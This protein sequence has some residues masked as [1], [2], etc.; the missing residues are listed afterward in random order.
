MAC[1]G[2][3]AIQLCRMEGGM[4]VPGWDTAQ[5]FENPEFERSPI[6]LGMS[7][8]VGFDREDDFRG[9]AALIKEK[10]E[11][12]RYKMKGFTIA[13][14]CELEDG[15][16]LF[17]SIDGSDVKIGTLPS[18]SWSHG[19]SQWLGLTSLLIA[20]AA[21]TEGFVV[22][23]DEKVAVSVCSIPFINFSRKLQ[24]PSAL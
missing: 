24:V 19:T 21:A 18:V 7:W 1:Y 20:H 8:N 6:E 16:E 3:T 11:G 10:A 14:E 5:L 4:I 2:L 12:S 23:N 17:A 22:V 15:A 13:V 9:K